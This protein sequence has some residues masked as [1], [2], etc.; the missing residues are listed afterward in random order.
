MLFDDI[1]KVLVILLFFIQKIRGHK[2]SQHIKRLY[3]IWN[4]GSII[5]CVIE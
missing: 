2:L 3:T 5:R 4:R 1:C